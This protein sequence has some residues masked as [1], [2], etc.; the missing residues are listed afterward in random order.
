MAAGSPTSSSF[1][2][3]CI[4]IELHG[5]SRNNT[6]LRALPLVQGKR[7]IELGSGCGLVGIVLA[8]LGA[9]VALTDLPMTMVVLSIYKTFILCAH[10]IIQSFFQ[11]HLQTIRLSYQWAWLVALSQYSFHTAMGEV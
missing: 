2:A 5:A 7:I 11:T 3:M 9:D 10:P 4:K 6:D 8:A 1:I